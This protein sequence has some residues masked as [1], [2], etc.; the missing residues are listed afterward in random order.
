MDVQFF[1]NSVSLKNLSLNVLCLYALSYPLVVHC[2]MTGA[3]TG[4]FVV[5]LFQALPILALAYLWKFRRK[6]QSLK[7]YVDVWTISLVYFTC[8]AIYFALFYAAENQFSEIV[9]SAR[10][11]SWFWLAATL[12]H[13]D[14]EPK[15]W[16]RLAKSFWIGATSQCAIA[17]WG[18]IWGFRNGLASTYSN[19]A[20]TTGSADVSGKTVVAFVVLGVALST[21]WFLTKRRLKLLYAATGLAGIAV[22]LGSYNRASQLGVA[23]AYC[24]ALSACL[25][26]KRFKAAG[27]LLGI[28]FA[29][30]LF[31]SSGYGSRFVTRWETVV[32]DKG[33]GR[34]AMIEIAGRC[35]ADPPSSEVLWFGRGVFQMQEMMYEEIGTRIG[36]HNDALDFAIAYGIVGGVLYL[37]AV[38]SV[39]SFRKRVP[40][41][42]VENYFL[43][44]TAIF[45]VLTGLCTGMFQATYVYFMLIATQYYWTSQVR[46]KQALWERKRMANEAAWA[47]ANRRELEEYWEEEEESEAD[48]FDENE[49]EELGTR[50]ESRGANYD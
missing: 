44:S 2:F 15:F 46:V 21:Y 38:G 24:F 31:I 41:Y 16:E 42:A 12:R 30:T 25:H 1:K 9:Y 4:T 40:R 5:Q 32:S 18:T 48:D 28:L 13:I 20:A 47:L 17:L 8:A 14:L 43:L 11:L 10:F 23:V 49:R 50:R 33:S 27:A 34:V 7:D 36:M 45:V 3:E 29:F 39:L 6:A 37:W 35:L 26:K 19:V 22:V